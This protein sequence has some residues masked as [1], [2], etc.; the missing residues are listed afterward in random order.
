MSEKS[1]RRAEERGRLPGLAGLSSATLATKVLGY[2]RDALLV[3]VFGG[4]AL[5]DTYYA[6]FRILNLFRRTV[7][8][9]AVNAGFIPA[10]E[11]EK[12]AAGDNGA[13]FFSAA[14][15]LIFFLSL[16]LAALGIL[17]REEL[18]K[19]IS[20][21]F[22]ARPE[23][24]ALAAAV[25]AVLMPH[26][27]FVNA[28]A[29]FQ[30]ALNSA[31]K[32]FLPA[33]APA[34]FSLVIIGYL[35]FIRSPLAPAL[36]PEAL[37]FGLAA[38]ATASGLVQAAALL[39]LLKKAGYGLKFSNPFKTPAAWRAMVFTAPAA[40]VMAQDQISLF[41]NT[42]F[43]SF[44]EPGSITAIYNAARLIQF[45][46]SLFAAAAAAISLPALARSAA[47]GRTA[48]F[49]LSLSASFKTTALIII[50]AALGLM[51]L[52][53]PISRALFEHGQFTREGSVLTAGVLFYLAL[54]LPAYGVN[55]LAAAACYGSGD[56]RTPV[57]VVLAQTALNA[58][59]CFLL[60]R[61]MGARGLALATALSS[62]AAAGLYLRSLKAL[63]SFSPGPAAFYCKSLAS[64][65][66]MGAFC[67]AVR[68]LLGG[69]P[70][71]LTAAVAV[72]CGAAVYLA[73]LK[74]LRLEER[75]LLTGG[76]F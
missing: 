17:F 61:P 65:A 7:G 32:F 76:S 43:A 67:L 57:K 51:A 29:L 26:L 73:G 22:T 20:Y 60:M 46:V 3:A 19:L 27:V 47:G 38:A 2:A 23:Q 71:L 54:G 45:P 70:P 58:G 72:P 13:R 56:I 1:R 49:G 12:A 10:L 24:F 30:A 18:V 75:A 37:I 62:L 50:P 63:G 41:I 74:A 9:G 40:A 16:A 31:G 69:F 35:F 68:H 55:K 53:L 48:D 64:A 39:P 25:T 5:T 28:S 33:L 42:M 66:F 14:W 6:A 36:S 34:A 44:L 15:T 11:K 59:L 8:E 4:G 21:G 52:D